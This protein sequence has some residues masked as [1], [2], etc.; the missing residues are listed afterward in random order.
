MNNV[1]KEKDRVGLVKNCLDLRTQF[2]ANVRTTVSQ[3]VLAHVE[4]VSHPSHKETHFLNA[5]EIKPEHLQLSLDGYVSRATA[6]S[7]KCCPGPIS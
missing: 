3:A 7:R 5:A 1:E 6:V 2:T 4:G